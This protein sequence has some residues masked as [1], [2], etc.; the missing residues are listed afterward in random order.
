VLTRVSWF[1]QQGS[2]GSEGLQSHELGGSLALEITP[3]RYLNARVLLMGRLPVGGDPPKPALG[4][5]G[6]QLGGAF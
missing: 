2:L 6:F 3:W 1:H 5:V 4:S